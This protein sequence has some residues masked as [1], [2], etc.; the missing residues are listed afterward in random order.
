MEIGNI[1]LADYIEETEK[2]AV[3]FKK[4]INPTK[5]LLLVAETEKLIQLKLNVTV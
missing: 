4:T 2:M 3:I 5:K 1:F